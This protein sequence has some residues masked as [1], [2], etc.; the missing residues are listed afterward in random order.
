MQKKLKWP[1]KLK[2]NS[3]P[4]M[5]QNLSTPM[6]GVLGMVELLLDTDLSEEQ[7]KFITV[8]KSSAGSLLGIIN[9]ILDFSKIEAGKLILESIDFNLRA[10]IEDFSA[11]VLF[12]ANE[13]GLSLSCNITND[14]PNLLN[15]D[16]GR[17]RQIL[18]N[19]VAN[20]AIK[21]TLWKNRILIQNLFQKQK[22]MQ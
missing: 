21:S 15:G 18:I 14:T 10:L 19:L 2:V 22:Q 13:K 8:I 3:L 7:S 12:R 17:I 5:S 20:M 11:M 6:N 9:D 4:D 16:P 1:A